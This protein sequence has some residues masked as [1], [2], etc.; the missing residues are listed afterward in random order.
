MII[1]NALSILTKM[2]NFVK[3]RTIFVMFLFSLF[4]FRI[5][6][7]YIASSSSFVFLTYNIGRILT[8]LVATH[9]IFTK[10]NN[11]SHAIN[12]NK[13]VFILLFLFFLSQ[14]IP[15]IN[16]INIVEY[17][18][19]Y[20]DLIFFILIFI[21]S[22]LLSDRKTIILSIYVLL[23]ASLISLGF[24][25]VEYHF[26]HVFESLKTCVE[27]N[28]YRFFEFQKKRGRFFGETLDEVVIP[29]IFFI[30]RKGWVSIF[31]YSLFILITYTTFISNWRTKT[32]IFI[33]VTIFS[34]VYTHSK[35]LVVVPSFPLLSMFV[36]ITVILAVNTS[37]INT[38]TSVTQRFLFTD[39]EDVYTTTERLKYWNIA[40]EIGISNLIFGV[41]IGNYYDY[42]N[43][44]E[45][46]VN[47]G[48]DGFFSERKFIVIDDPHNI[49]F[50][51]F[52][53]TGIVG[54]FFIS[55]LFFYFLLSDFRYL[56]RNGGDSLVYFLCVS[57][58]ALFFF[59]FFNPFFYWQFLYFLAILR[60]FLEK[61]KYIK[62]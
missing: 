59:S 10:R 9:L 23:I 52:A 50:S 26:T 31:Y 22:Y 38:G 47:I 3:R 13:F 1:S 45:Q 5:P 27:Q 7:F 36:L 24:Q 46:M 43:N 35:K 20:K 15:I 48:K 37:T 16:A 32:I 61:I 8:L 51:T 29:L 56:K 34:Y 49:F 40:R 54:L 18:K 39:S 6:P 41:G 11:I 55:S 12:N 30:Y 57:S 58:W 44:K 33:L 17:L 2:L 25:M 28:Y 4:L 21:N 19:K 42:L 14:S 60:G 53:S 62:R